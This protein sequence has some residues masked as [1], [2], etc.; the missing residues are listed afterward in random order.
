[1]TMR[2]INKESKAILSIFAKQLLDILN[3]DE[4]ESHKVTR[5][6]KKIELWINANDLHPEEV[7]TRK[8]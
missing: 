3:S 2:Y 5:I 7:I 8:S 4:N 6:R 1:M